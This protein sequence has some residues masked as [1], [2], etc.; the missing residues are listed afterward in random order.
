MS[1]ACGLL[2]AAATS[3]GQESLSAR[4]AALSYSEAKPVLEALRQDLLPAEMRGKTAAEIEA[5][6]PAWVS[7]RDAEIRARVEDGDADS[8]INLLQFGTTFTK[9]RRITE[10]EPAG[11]QVRQA[12]TGVTVFVPS[13]LLKARI[14]DFVAALASPGENERLRFARRVIERRGM[15]LA[16]ENGR[17]RIRRYLEQRTE[18]VGSAPHA[19]TLVDPDAELRDLTTIF[20]DRGLAS[21]TA[22]WID[23]GIERA[24]EAMKARQLIQPSAIRRIAI[25]GP[26]LDFADKQEGQDFYP[27]QTLQ[28]FALVDSLMRLGLSASGGLQVTAFDLSPRVL[29]HLETARMRARSGTPYTLVLPRDLDQPWTP[30]LTRYWETFGD[31]VGAVARTAAPPPTAG[32]LAVRSIRVPPVAVLS[33]YPRDVNI[34]VQRLESLNQDERFDLIVASNILIY[35]DVFEQSLAVSNLAAMLRPGGLLLSNDR[36]FELPDGPV[37]SVGHTDVTYMELPGGGRRGD[38]IEWYQRR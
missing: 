29:Q 10:R 23:F 34:V 22:I 28:P 9:Q 7:R 25:L 36:I 27:E 31:R 21:D 30:D 24:L 8:I 19:G 26:G 13:P 32:R 15:E 5:V 17:N 3:A 1:I 33:V 38:R 20:R 37:A 2:L 35:Y 12:G 16:T 18:V 11:V 6:W 14:E 4:R